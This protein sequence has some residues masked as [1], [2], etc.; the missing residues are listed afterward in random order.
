MASERR[1]SAGPQKTAALKPPCVLFHRLQMFI[2]QVCF[3][4]DLQSGRQQGHRGPSRPLI[5]NNLRLP[6]KLPGALVSRLERTRSPG[7]PSV[8]G[9]WIYPPGLVSRLEPT[10]TQTSFTSEVV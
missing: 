3:G 10:V 9:E 4:E 7:K 2:E 6:N 1:G 8:L 5:L